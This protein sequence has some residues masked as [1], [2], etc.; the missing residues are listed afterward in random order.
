MR[1]KDLASNTFFSLT[2]FCLYCFL[3]HVRN[4]SGIMPRSPA[5]R[6]FIAPGHKPGPHTIGPRGYNG[7]TVRGIRWMQRRANLMVHGANILAFQQTMQR[8]TALLRKG[9]GRVTAQD[10]TS[11]NI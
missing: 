6:V 2:S 7:E 10:R 4:K 1:Q 11:L 5:S 3:S 8:D 9:A